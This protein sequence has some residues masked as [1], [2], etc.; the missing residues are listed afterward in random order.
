[1]FAYGS[2]ALRPQDGRLLLDAAAPDAEGLAHVE[3][4]L[5][6]HLERFGARHELTVE[7]E[8]S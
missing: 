5:Q 4:V 3:D 7:W 1:M 8:R 6:R 2:A